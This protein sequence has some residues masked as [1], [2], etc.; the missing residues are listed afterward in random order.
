MN[1]SSD[2]IFFIEYLTVTPFFTCKASGI[3]SWACGWMKILSWKL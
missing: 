3:E 2:F 1:E